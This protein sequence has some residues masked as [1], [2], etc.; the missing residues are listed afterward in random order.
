LVR[1]RSSA[2]AESSV[3]LFQPLRRCCRADQSPA[4][5]PA[6]SSINGNGAGAIKIS[7]TS[8]VNDSAVQIPA[9]V[10]RG[11]VRPKHHLIANATNY[12]LIEIDSSGS[13]TK[14]VRYLT[15]V[16]RNPRQRLKLN[17]GRQLVR[18]DLNGS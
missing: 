7:I 15:R 18:R 17:I 11:S 3:S 5:N 10:A 14:S 16:I 9:G 4:A 12:S 6:T 1:E 13:I 8:H 2:P